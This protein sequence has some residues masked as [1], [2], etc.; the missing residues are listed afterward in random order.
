MTTEEGLEF[1]F[2]TISVNFFS[3]ERKEGLSSF[4]EKRKAGYAKQ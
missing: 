4:L 2:E 1:E 3:E